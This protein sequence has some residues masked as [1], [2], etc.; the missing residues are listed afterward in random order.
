MRATNNQDVDAHKPAYIQ[1]GLQWA[2]L[3]PFPTVYFAVYAYNGRKLQ[4]ILWE[5]VTK[6][7][8]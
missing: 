7:L 5:I 4:N 3:L 1:N 8:T 6:I 2:L